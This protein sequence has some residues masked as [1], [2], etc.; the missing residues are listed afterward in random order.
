MYKMNELLRKI[1]KVDEVFKEAAWA[2]LIG[3]FPEVLAKEAL[4]TFLDTLRLDIKG[5]KAASV[6]PMETIIAAVRKEVEKS[7]LPT[8]KG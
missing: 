6:Q 3:T 8:S 5:G 2:E 4:R 7:G 1:P